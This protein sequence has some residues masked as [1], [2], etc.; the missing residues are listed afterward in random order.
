MRISFFLALL[1]LVLFG[2]S[3]APSFIDGSTD[4]SEDAA[5][6]SIENVLEGVSLGRTISPG[7][8]GSYRAAHDA[9]HRHYRVL[10]DRHHINLAKKPQ[11]WTV[12]VTTPD[13]ESEG[14]EMILDELDFDVRRKALKSNST[15]LEKGHYAPPEIPS[16]IDYY[17]DRQ[18]YYGYH[19][20]AN[21]VIDI[22]GIE[23]SPI[24]STIY[25]VGKAFEE[26]SNSHGTNQ[27][28]GVDAGFNQDWFVRFQRKAI[29]Q[30]E[31]LESVHP[32]FQTLVGPSSVAAG[33][34][35]M[36]L[37]LTLLWNVG[38]SAAMESLPNH[39]IYDFDELR[40][41]GLTLSS[42][43]AGAVLFVNGDNDTYPLLYL[44]AVKGYRQDVRV[45]NC[46][47]LN[48]RPYAEWVRRPY[49]DAAPLALHLVPDEV[50]YDLAIMGSEEQ[51]CSVGQMLT[52]FQDG[53][54]MF[55]TGNNAWPILPAKT[56]FFESH[57]GE[58][59]LNESKPYLLLGEIF[60]RDI[61]A[62]NAHNHP[63][64]F[65]ITTAPSLTEAFSPYLR[66][67][68]MVHRLT[69]KRHS[70]QDRF[71]VDG[72]MSWFEDAFPLP[73]GKRVL[74]G[75]LNVV[76]TA[77]E[78]ASGLVRNNR[79]RDAQKVVKLTMAE[80]PID[81]TTTSF[82]YKLLIEAAF[83]TEL[84]REALVWAAD[85]AANIHNQ[86]EREQNEKAIKVGRMLVERWISD[87]AP[88]GLDDEFKRLLTE[89]GLGW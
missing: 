84:K 29:H 6:G 48:L 87:L 1:A 8:L 11:G 80:F 45:V 53:L 21:D 27:H 59:Q 75:E 70:E 19:G 65:A 60:L 3:E 10:S 73:P 46:S 57:T 33:N 4:Q 41:A 32:A 9:F 38:E 68:G 69:S 40:F 28:K 37:F 31:R 52:H 89:R 42:C 13:R 77:G 30:M 72:T 85:L 54:E 2:C 83:E 17:Y 74:R 14:G 88:F 36:H 64:C 78:L 7:H 15:Y 49:L 63:I 44:Q 71:D 51:A 61:M 79:L 23:S 55:E 43:A 47:L 12:Q 39:S 50:K 76:Y 18:I 56:F 81:S 86:D 67:T 66:Q 58:V 5:Q 82:S 34:A 25:A 22:P 62:S 24:D 35:H 20:W 26:L 16:A